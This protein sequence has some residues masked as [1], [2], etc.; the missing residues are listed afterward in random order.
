LIVVLQNDTW[1]TSNIGLKLMEAVIEVR[2]LE[3]KKEEEEARDDSEDRKKM[4]EERWILKLFVT[5]NYAGWAKK[6]RHRAELLGFIVVGFI[7][8]YLTMPVSNR[9]EE[10]KDDDENEM[11]RGETKNE[12]KMKFLM[13][14]LLVT[15]IAAFSTFATVFVVGRPNLGLD[16]L[17]HSGVFEH[18][19]S[20][21]ALGMVYPPKV[22]AALSKHLEEKVRR[23]NNNDKKGEEGHTTT[24]RRRKI[25]ALDF[26]VDHWRLSKSIKQYIVVPCLLE[27]TR[28]VSSLRVF[29]NEEDEVERFKDMA[30]ASRFV[31]DV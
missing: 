24:K 2:T 9:R 22:A 23:F 21:S 5:T 31:D 26:E 29:G 18:D 27:H 7:V 4:E 19:F 1:A 10:E 17:T 16:S 3:K 12:R 25:K 20:T 6:N 13:M 15:L 8:G 28:V 14:R 30:M 11:Q